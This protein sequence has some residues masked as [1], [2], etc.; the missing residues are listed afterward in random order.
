MK[1]IISYKLFESSENDETL[2]ELI[3]NLSNISD[4]LGQPSINK[5]KF[6]ELMMYEFSWELGIDLA[7]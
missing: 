5:E 1:S 4:L 7:D 3:D 2:S 6:G